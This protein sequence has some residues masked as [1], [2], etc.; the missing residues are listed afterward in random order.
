M[1]TDLRSLHNVAPNI[2]WGDKEGNVRRQRGGPNY[3]NGSSDRSSGYLVAFIK[4]TTAKAIVHKVCFYYSGYNGNYTGLAINKSNVWQSTS[5]VSGATCQ[6]MT[7]PANK[8]SV[9]VLKSGS[10]YYTNWN[11]QYTRMMIGFYNDTWKLPVG[12]EWDYEAYH[13]WTANNY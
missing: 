9:V 7:I 11:G 10:R 1:P 13:N 8:S 12:I 4:N 2:I 6:N 3:G 5:N